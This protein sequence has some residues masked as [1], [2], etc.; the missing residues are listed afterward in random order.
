MLF[1][2]QLILV[3]SYRN[4]ATGSG[5][6]SRVRLE[7]FNGFVNTFGIWGFFSR[8]LLEFFQQASEAIRKFTKEADF[9]LH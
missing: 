7:R 8:K 5:K 9:K 2:K 4:V 6:L 1:V 3:Y